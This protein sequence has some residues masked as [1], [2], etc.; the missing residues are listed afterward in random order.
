MINGRKKGH[1][2]ER[3]IAKKLNDVI[4]AVCDD[5]KR[6]R[7]I[8]P[9]VQRNQNQSAVGGLDLVGTLIFGI[10]IKRC[11]KP[12]IQTWWK[13]V[14]AAADVEDKEP[15]LIY[16]IDRGAWLVCMNASIHGE[17]YRVT[18]PLDSFLDIFA[19]QFEEYF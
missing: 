8:F 7:P 16:K 11:Q 14:V 3:F 19:K 5:W 17:V 18:I 12:A 4:N 6:P 1:D 13:Q 15:V 10:E 2:A 9:Q